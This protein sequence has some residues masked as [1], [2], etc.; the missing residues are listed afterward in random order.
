[1][2]STSNAFNQHIFACS[3]FPWSYEGFR[4]DPFL[5]LRFLLALI[6]SNLPIRVTLEAGIIMYTMTC[7]FFI[8]T[9]LPRMFDDLLYT[10]KPQPPIFTK[11]FSKPLISLQEPW[12]P[13]V[14]FKKAT[15]EAR[16]VGFDGQFCVLL[17]DTITPTNT[18]VESWYRYP[19][20]NDHIYATT[21]HFKDYIFYFSCLVAYVHSLEGLW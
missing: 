3:C 6:F 5:T 9:F 13:I 10:D 1:M 17:Y 8:Y 18:L 11:L 4:V 21:W 20:G 2:E 19:D 14:L 16:L 7:M 15:M 12:H